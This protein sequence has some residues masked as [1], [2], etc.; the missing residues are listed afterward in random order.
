ML[1]TAYACV[2][3]GFCFLLSYPQS[4]YLR[5]KN[6]VL[7]YPLGGGRGATRPRELAPAGGA[8][9]LLCLCLMRLGF[10]RRNGV[11]VPHSRAVLLNEGVDN[12]SCFGCWKVFNRRRALIK[13]QG[14]YWPYC[15]KSV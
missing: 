6:P 7:P 5:L 12:F 4:F 10:K 1:A 13:H 15:P 11:F 9:L 2:C 8:R 3:G 14:R